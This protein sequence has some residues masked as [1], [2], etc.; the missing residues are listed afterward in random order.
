MVCIVLASLIAG[1][2]TGPA[3]QPEQKKETVI[4]SVDQINAYMNPDD[5]PELEAIIESSA[6]STIRERAVMALG[7]V[8]I[9]A[10]LTD[11]VVP[12]LKKVALEEEDSVVRSAAYANLDLIRELYPEEKVGRLDLRIEGTIGAGQN[13]SLIATVSSSVN[14]DRALV[15]IK[16]IIGGDGERTDDITLAGAQ[17]MPIQFPLVA[18]SSKEIPIMLHIN[19]EGKY[20]IFYVFQVDQ[21][22]VDSQVIE[23]E[24]YIYFEN[25][26]GKYQVFG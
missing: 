10:N 23:K 2:T 11:D 5:I 8:S 12:F 26:I 18:G 21:D 7:D 22:R 15:G 16:K 1:C 17:R 9:R 13:I 19:K 24:V 4:Q 6:N 14:T 20:S 25:G 3:P